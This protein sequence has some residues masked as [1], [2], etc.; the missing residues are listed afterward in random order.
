MAHSLGGLVCA[1]AV[2][3]SYGSDKAKANLVEKVR[4]MVFLGTP[5]AG[6][7]K[8]KWARIA[9]GLLAYLATTN[10]EKVKDLE[11]RCKLL[12]DINHNF[13]QFV[14]SRDRNP[15]WVEIACYFEEIPTRVK[16]KDIG[17]IVEK[18]SATLEGHQ[19]LSIQEE[20]ADMCK[21][22]DEYR[23]GFISIA[24]KLNAWIKGFEKNQ[25]DGK[26]ASGGGTQNN[27]NYNA[28]ISNNHGAI[29]GQATSTEKDG[30]RIIGS[31]KKII[32][33]NNGARASRSVD[34]DDDDDSC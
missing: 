7:K 33:H 2:S 31:T 4:G 32:Y 26:T 21:F 10:V 5:F 34:D 28:P 13:S 8:A 15:P 14:K 19:P 12:E 25:E 6:S 20:H 27:I 9:A 17:Y 29:V 16:G 22:V 11:E 23:N 30:L 3:K 24:D 18:E 1:N